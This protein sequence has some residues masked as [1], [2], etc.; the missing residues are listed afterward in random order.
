MSAL[1]LNALLSQFPR[2]DASDVLAALRSI[3]ISVHMSVHVSV[4]MSA[5]M[6]IR[7]RMIPIS[8]GILVMAY[9]LWH[10]R[11]GILVMAY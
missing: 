4:H 6:S 2:L 1:S 9:H 5:H 7:M 3:H 10:I 11:Y 8:Y